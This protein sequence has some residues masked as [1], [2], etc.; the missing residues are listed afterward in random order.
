MIGIDWKWFYNRN[1]LEKVSLDEC[2]EKFFTIE[3]NCKSFL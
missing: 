3:I 1:S 2:I